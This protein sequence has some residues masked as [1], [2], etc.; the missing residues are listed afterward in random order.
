VQENFSLT[1]NPNPFR[2]YAF[3]QFSLPENATVKIELF[4]LS[5]RKIKT[6]AEGAFQAGNHE[7][8]LSAEN[9]EKGIYFLQLNTGSD[10]AFQKI[11]LQ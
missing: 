4:D 11:A 1:I 8:N 2:Q 5:G 10:I 6:I 7:L 3:I 9:M